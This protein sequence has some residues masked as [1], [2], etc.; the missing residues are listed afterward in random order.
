[1]RNLLSMSVARAL[2]VMTADDYAQYGG[3][4]TSPRNAKPIGEVASTGA[5]WAAD[6]DC[7][8]YWAH[9]EPYNL[10]PLL[11]ALERWQPHAKTCLFINAPDVITNAKATLEQFWRWREIIVSY[12]YPVAFSVQD[13]VED[14]SPPWGAF[15]ALFIGATNRT[16]YSSHV[17]RLV[18][19]ALTRGVWVHNGRVNVPSSVRYARAIGCQSFDGTAYVRNLSFIKRVLPYQKMTVPALWDWETIE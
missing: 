13:G 3:M 2:K 4:L 5:P 7:Y 16:K 14:Y 11:R 9:N 8:G 10:I 1:M 19:E 6:N 18:T 12:G 17:A 15:D